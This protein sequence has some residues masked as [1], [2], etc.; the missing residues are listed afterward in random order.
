M[1]GWF[2]SQIHLIACSRWRGMGLPLWGLRLIYNMQLSLKLHMYILAVGYCRCMRLSVRVCVRVC[3]P[4]V[5]RDIAHHPFQLGSP[6]LAQKCKMSLLRFLLFWG[7]IN[8]DLRGFSISIGNSTG[9]ATEPW[10]DKRPRWTLAVDI[11]EDTNTKSFLLCA[12]TIYITKRRGN[13]LV[14]W[15]IMLEFMDLRR[16][17][18]SLWW[19]HNGGDSV[20]NHQP[21][22]CLPNR[23]I[24]CR[25]KNPSK[26]RVAG[27][28]VG[29]NGQ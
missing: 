4:E 11:G 8:L 17:S 6:Y 12:H 23:L 1:T 2:F 16:T 9:N 27:L 20:S 22:E 7:A 5:V 10:I 18:I 15:L 19:R 3:Q 21:R 13:W 25:S 26:L 28:C 29:T 14:K 24:R